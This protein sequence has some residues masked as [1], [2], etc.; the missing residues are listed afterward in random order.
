MPGCYR[1]K[2]QSD[3]CH[4][5]IT[6]LDGLTPTWRLVHAAPSK[7]DMLPMDLHDFVHHWPTIK[8]DWCMVILV[9]RLKEPSTTKILVDRYA[10]YRKSA[11]GPV[12]A[13]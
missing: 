5:H 8:E 12:D 1:I 2:K 13:T 7:D 3:Y 4:R 11:E 6:V 9:A 10:T